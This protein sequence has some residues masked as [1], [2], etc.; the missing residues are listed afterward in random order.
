MIAINITQYS[1]KMEETGFARFYKDD[2]VV[3]DTSV[4]QKETEREVDATLKG[5]HQI[6]NYQ[7]YVKIDNIK[8]HS[9]FIGIYIYIYN[10]HK[11]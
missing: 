9:K 11:S 3:T 2:F 4:K 10:S 6:E 7:Q 5:P 1:S 8:A